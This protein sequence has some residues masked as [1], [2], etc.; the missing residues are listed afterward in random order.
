MSGSHPTNG[1]QIEGGAG[2]SLAAH[3]KDAS[4]PS[5][6]P[7]AAAPGNQGVQQGG[8]SAP[9]SDTVTRLSEQARD[10]ASQAAGAASKALGQAR[11]R[12]L[13]VATSEQVAEFVRDRPLIA[14]LGA[15]AVGLVVGML[16]SRR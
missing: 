2:P 8:A 7:A 5:S 16:L 9:G 3:S 14:L 15:G 4:A 13:P 1:K 10:A 12:L 6:N 11:E